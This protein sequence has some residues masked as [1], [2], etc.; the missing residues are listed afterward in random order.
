M[1]LTLSVL[2]DDDYFYK[3]QYRDRVGRFVFIYQDR[4]ASG[5]WLAPKL[6]VDLMIDKQ[7]EQSLTAID[8]AM[9]LLQ[10]AK[11][12]MNDLNKRVTQ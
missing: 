8:E 6:S 5:Q 10:Q 11:Q 12:I 1:M 4:Y 7:G 2:S 9:V 3:A